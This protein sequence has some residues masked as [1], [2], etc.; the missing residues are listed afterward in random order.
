MLVR[1]L[2]NNHL[3]YLAHLFQ[4]MGVDE[5]GKKIMFLKAGFYLIHIDS[6]NVPASN[7]LKQEMLSLGGD[8]ALHRGA[9]DF[10][11]EETPCLLMG[12]AQQ[13]QQLVKKLSIQPF[14]LKKVGKEI[15]KS[16]ERFACIPPPIQ[17]G[18][19]RLEFSKG[20]L[21]MGILNM[22]PDS[23]S[24][25]GFSKRA[26]Q[27]LKKVEKFM[28][29]GMDILD[30]GGEST[31]PG[32]TPVSPEEERKR[33]IP[34][35]KAIAKRFSIPISIDTTK[36]E[37]ARPAL[38]AGAVIVNDV[39]GFLHEPAILETARQYDAPVVLMHPERTSR[40]DLMTEMGEFFQKR[41]EYL[42]G[43]GILEEKVILDP[44]IGFGKTAEE[45]LL[46]LRR[47]GELKSFGRPILLGVSRKSFI[48]R[49]LNLDVGK[50]S[51]G[52]LSSAVLGY[53]QGVRIFRVHEVGETRQGLRMC[54]AILESAAPNKL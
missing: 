39:S 44:G 3:D 19:Y 6:L 2:S 22:T 47:I 18:S 31:R 12:T 30:V 51:A 50:R 9:C 13:F 32:S 54:R 14:G 36:A 45:N 35:I 40:K 28:E 37:V 49:V 33:V 1:V 38:E 41:L 8:A 42:A 34:A 25:D 16:I 48:G 27:A 43:K 4:E 5:V 20:P 23:F 46:I 10:S 15:Q 29:E 53:R 17:A 11:R 7:I 24:G 21:V 26:D 52:S